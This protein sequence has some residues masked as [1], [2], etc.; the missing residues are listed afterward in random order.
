MEALWR[1]AA[2]GQGLVL[3]VS[4]EPGVG[5]TRLLRELIVRAQV[6]GGI[7]LMG[8]AYVESGAPYA[9][10]AEMIRQSMESA[11]APGLP[12]AILADLLALAP[13]LCARYPNVPTNP[14]LDAQSEQQRLFESVVAWCIALSGRTPLM[15]VLDDA[16]WADSGT[17]ALLHHLARR[18][19]RP[20]RTHCC[21]LPGGGA[22][23]GAALAPA[24]RRPEPRAPIDA[25]QAGAPGSGA[26]AHTAGCALPGR[27]PRRLSGAIYQETEG[28][29]F[30]V[31]EV[32]K[33]LIEDGILSFG[34]G[35]WRRGNMDD[36]HVPQSVRL[37][38]QMRVSKLP[39][40][41]QDTLRLAAVLGRQFEYEIL[42][43]ASDQDEDALIAAL[44]DAERAQLLAEV[45]SERADAVQ[46]S[47]A[48]ALIAATLREGLGTLRRQRLHRRAA[49]AVEAARPDL[50]E[51]LAYHWHQA[52]DA[53][54]ARSFYVRAGER[55]LAIYAYREAEQSLLTALDL[56]GQ[57]AEAAQA[58]S[59]LGE[60]QFEL[61]RLGDAAAS[62]RR[63]I[64]LYRDLVNN[65]AVARLYARLAHSAWQAG[66]T[67]QAVE[68]AAEGMATLAGQA[69]TP[70]LGA[71]L[72]EAAR[73]SY[74]SARAAE[75]RPLVE[76]ALRIAEQ[77]A[78]AELM[79]QSLSTLG[80]ILQAEGRTEEATG[81]AHRAVQ[82]AEDAGL[83]L[84]AC[85]ALNNL[86]SALS[87][88]AGDTRGARACNERAAELARRARVPAQEAFQLGNVIMLTYD[89]GELA[90]MEDLVHSL[91]ALVG[92]LVDPGQAALQLSFSEIALCQLRGQLDEAE[93]LIRE[94]VVLASRR[95]NAYHLAGLTT[96]LVQVLI[97]AGQP[98][99]AESRMLSVL[100]LS[101]ELGNGI[102]PRCLLC[103][104][105]AQQGHRIDARRWLVEA[106]S[107]AGDTVTRFDRCH[108][109]RAGA[110]LAVCEKDW[111]EAL[112][113]FQELTDELARLEQRPSQ[114]LILR[115]W[116]DFHLARGEAGDAV[117]AGELLQEALA[118][119]EAMGSQHYVARVRGRLD[120]LAANQAGE[121]SSSG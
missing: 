54:R 36:I 74:F 67:G 108:L 4:G 81:A 61:G 32:C 104:A 110:A 99:E 1:Q 62:W 102:F 97:E 87:D 24:Y 21:C 82:V 40:P 10:I 53:E 58:L 79:A 111:G 85:R 47:F 63:A 113:Q 38:I 45:Q 114:A 11:S 119:Y 59:G 91:R 95:G 6:G 101:D 33:A 77:T 3:L 94:A 17:L 23:R 29:A 8:A 20:E 26:D 116:A 112:H 120:E 72:H 48:H 106:R 34:D 92:S 49:S 69:D 19:P 83:L 121:T 96:S 2:A 46:F 107:A 98:A 73:V 60:A 27:D 43:K 103:I 14:R 15:L 57:P 12:D 37:A 30:F 56:G 5:K 9:P 41:T 35:R 39:A 25:R 80:L 84:A 115:E 7:A 31:E 78:D 109:L 52:G 88:G 117:R 50:V 100:E 64:V 105:C 70:G 13:D 44:E 51:A 118:L 89:L 86:G 66:E 75:G 90:Y 76:R 71:L 93:R 18:L 55:S 22:G 16:H 65:D 42:K 28:N 68:I